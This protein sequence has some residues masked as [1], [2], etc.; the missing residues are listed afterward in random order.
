[1]VRGF[2]LSDV[3]R[4]VRDILMIDLGAPA[5]RGSLL[6]CFCGMPVEIPHELTLHGFLTAEVC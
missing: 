2:Q 6:R 5:S 3:L 1:M 4:E